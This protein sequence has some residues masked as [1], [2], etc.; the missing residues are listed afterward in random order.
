M[1]RA[2]GAC[3]PW[4]DFKTAINK[5]DAKKALE[6]LMKAPALDNEK[7]E[8]GVIPNKETTEVVPLTPAAALVRDPMDGLYTANPTP[9][10]ERKNPLH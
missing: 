1:T 6:Q 8:D 3:I 2:I 9:A 7:E 5:R 4:A 10:V